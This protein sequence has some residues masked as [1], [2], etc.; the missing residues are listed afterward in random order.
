MI[1][2]RTHCGAPGPM[3]SMMGATSRGPGPWGR[4]G[5][6][7]GLP[8]GGAGTDPGRCGW[9]S[10]VSP[11]AVEIPVAGPVAWPSWIDRHRRPLTAGR[12]AVVADSAALVPRHRPQW[13]GKASAHLGHQGGR[14]PWPHHHRP[15]GTSPLPD[16]VYETSLHVSDA[17]MPR[18]P[19]HHHAID[20]TATSPLRPRSKRSAEYLKESCVQ[21]NATDIIE[22]PK[23]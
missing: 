1:A 4:P 19:L 5:G 18:R 11:T 22:T 7:D 14:Q 3:G 13:G 15:G 8:P 10:R 6:P 21:R 17:K 20:S 23:R 9:E 2:P 16:G 12:F